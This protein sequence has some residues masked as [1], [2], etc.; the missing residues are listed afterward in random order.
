MKNDLLFLFVGGFMF[1][2]MIGM[3]IILFGGALYFIEKFIK[4]VLY[5]NVLI[6][7]GLCIMVLAAI[8]AI[9]AWTL[10]GAGVF[11]A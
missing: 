9:L 8:C 5:S 6:I 11:N 1:L 3:G 4:R 7:I 2:P 10:G